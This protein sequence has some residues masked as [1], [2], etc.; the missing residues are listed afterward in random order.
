MFT[1]AGFGRLWEPSFENECLWVRVRLCARTCV[2]CGRG[3]AFFL[4]CPLLLCVCYPGLFQWGGLRN[5]SFGIPGQ[6]FMPSPRGSDWKRGGY[7]QRHPRLPLL[8]AHPF[9]ARFHFS[10]EEL[11]PVQCF[12][13][14]GSPSLHLDRQIPFSVQSPVYTK[15]SN[16]RSRQLIDICLKKVSVWIFKVPKSQY[17]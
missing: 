2:M 7:W 14:T 1:H 6:S 10:P 13:P 5:Y 4:V 16:M 9:S 12:T 15:C 3:C 17:R 11:T 8:F